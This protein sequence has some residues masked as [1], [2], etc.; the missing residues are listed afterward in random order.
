M[1]KTIEQKM[2][3]YRSGTIEYKGKHKKSQNPKTTKFIHHRSTRTRRVNVRISETSQTPTIIVNYI[4]Y[5]LI[6]LIK[7]L[8]FY[9]IPL[10]MLTLGIQLRYTCKLA[11][12][13][14]DY[15]QV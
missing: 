8:L 10:G 9:F 6:I 1:G 12:A 7:P 2:T 14:V 11:L 5:L 15:Q 4:F 13:L 3:T